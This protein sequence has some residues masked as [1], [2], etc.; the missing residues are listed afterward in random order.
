MA[1]ISAYERAVMNA[2]M[3]ARIFMHIAQDTLSASSSFATRFTLTDQELEALRGIS[4]VSAHAPPPV[5][6]NMNI[7]G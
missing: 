6:P 4:E 2:E 7:P 5:S 1:G 3:A